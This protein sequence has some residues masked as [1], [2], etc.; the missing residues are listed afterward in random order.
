M[1]RGKAP[2]S[3]TEDERGRDRRERER[4]NTIMS[5]IYNQDGKC[6]RAIV[7]R[8]G[9]KGEFE[10]GRRAIEAQ[11]GGGKRQELGLQYTMTEW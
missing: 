1:Q 3:R 2:G 7:R 10:K 9:W 8:K 6:C 4:V 11:G 5:K